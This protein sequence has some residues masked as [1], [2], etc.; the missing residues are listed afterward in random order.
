MRKKLIALAVLV[1]AVP[2][3]TACPPAGD[4][5]N[6]GTVTKRETK[7][8]TRTGEPWVYLTIK[9]NKGGTKEET[10][11][12]KANVIDCKVGSTWPACV[13]KPVN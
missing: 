4:P 6:Q 2:F 12:D 8:D 3:L 5:E 1:S 9:L 11:T 10:Y 7:P 13:G